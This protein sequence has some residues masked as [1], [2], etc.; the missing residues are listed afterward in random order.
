MNDW[1]GQ[2]RNQ[3]LFQFISP[4]IVAVFFGFPSVTI[5]ETVEVE[6][7]FVIELPDGWEQQPQ[8]SPYAYQ[9]SK[10]SASLII[11]YYPFADTKNEI[12]KTAMDA[13]PD[14][15]GEVSPEGS[16]SE[17]LVNN[18]Q[19]RWGVYSGENE[20][21]GIK[22]K[23]Y[24]LVGAIA[25]DEESSL[26]FLSVLSHDK[27]EKWEK[28][29]E[30]SFYSIRLPGEAMTGAKKEGTISAEALASSNAPSTSETPF[31]HE[32]LS[33]T[34]PAGWENK[35]IPDNFEEEVIGW[36]DDGQSGTVMA[37]CLTGFFS[38]ED[39]SIDQAKSTAE[40]GL[41]NV[42]QVKNDKVDLGN[43]KSGTLQKFNGSSVYEGTEIHLSMVTLT[44][45]T[46]ECW[47]NLIGTTSK[48][49]EGMTQKILQLAQSA[50]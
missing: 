50:K 20:Y 1:I 36:F 22:V 16:L 9:F 45:K 8:A 44:F 18:H 17:L 46:E 21:Q 12:W 30:K 32:L 24:F 38:G 43:G 42:K 27:K 13:V 40:A 47:L 39:S 29:V 11:G 41:P 48:Q 7:R 34:L 3:I 5:G 28:A 31:R 49:G 35:T 6:D 14:D 15:L 23:L 4:I 33:L 10:E 26:T 19:A 37:L 2:F 25:L